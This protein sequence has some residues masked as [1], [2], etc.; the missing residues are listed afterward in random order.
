METCRGRDAPSDPA[1]CRGAT[2]RRECRGLRNAGHLRVAP[3]HRPHRANLAAEVSALRAS[4]RTARPSLC[5]RPPWACQGRV[6]PARAQHSSTESCPCQIRAL[7][8]TLLDAVASRADGAR[9][10]PSGNHHRCRCRACGRHRGR[11]CCLPRPCH[12]HD[13]SPD[14]E[15]GSL[16]APLHHCHYHAGRQTP[17]ALPPMHRLGCAKLRHCRRRQHRW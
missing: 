16:S 14:V 9:T 13:R 3:P 15:R 11:D 4:R 5:P 17:R 6:H 1:P 10:L 2:A 8:P 7:R 12:L